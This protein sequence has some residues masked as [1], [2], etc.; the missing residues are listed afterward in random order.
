MV[1]CCA[2]VFQTICLETSSVQPIYEHIPHLIKV[3]WFN[4]PEMCL[5]VAEREVKGGGGGYITG[6][7]HEIQA[8]PNTV[9]GEIYTWFIIAAR[10][11]VLWRLGRDAG[12][13]VRR[14]GLHFC[15]YFT[16]GAFTSSLSVPYKCM[17]LHSAELLLDYG[18]RFL[19]GLT[20]SLT[21]HAHLTHPVTS[22][23]NSSSLV[24][25]PKH[26]GR[27]QWSLTVCVNQTVFI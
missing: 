6:G 4:L 8:P 15:L 18:L 9:T 22:D 3:D 27:W 26:L 10:S 21:H 13:N 25:K 17:V 20:L 23:P 7:T 2:F 5:C 1:R 19:W 14:S 11:D 12:W 24:I 16:V